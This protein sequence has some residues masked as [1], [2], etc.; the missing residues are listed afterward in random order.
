MD[1]VGVDGAVLVS[2]YAMYRYEARYAVDV[3]AAHP[4]RFALVKPVNPTDPAVTVQLAF[5]S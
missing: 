4:S 5:A 2:P 3:H 1:A